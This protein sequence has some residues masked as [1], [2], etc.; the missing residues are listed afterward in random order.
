LINTIILLIGLIASLIKKYCPCSN[1]TNKVNPDPEENI[2]KVEELQPSDLS[3][4]NRVSSYINQTHSTHDLNLTPYPNTEDIN[5]SN[6]DE[7]KKEEIRDAFL[8]RPNKN[9]KVP[10]YFSSKNH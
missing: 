8:R 10:S 9:Q 3:I 2:D 6:K 7:E 5:K 1:K 4:P